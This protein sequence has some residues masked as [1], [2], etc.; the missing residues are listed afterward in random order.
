MRKTAL[1]DR[2]QLARQRSKNHQQ[3]DLVAIPRTSFHADIERDV[4]S[5]PYSL[6]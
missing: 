1:L 6:Q 2:D 5:P 4:L 3:E